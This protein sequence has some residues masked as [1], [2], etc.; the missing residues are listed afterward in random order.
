MASVLAASMSAALFLAAPAAADSPFKSLVGTWSGSGTARLEG[1]KSERLSCKGYYSG[2]GG[3]EL[4][5]NIICAN[6]STK[7]ELRSVLKYANGKVSGTWE[8]RNFNQQGSVSGSATDSKLHLAIAGGAL[9]GS[10]SVSF[11][12]SSQS[13]SLSTQGSALKGVSITFSRIG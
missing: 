12:G 1:G 6:P 13:V 5:L 8:E 3:T 4:R 11:G 9:S 7:V 10:L 2:S